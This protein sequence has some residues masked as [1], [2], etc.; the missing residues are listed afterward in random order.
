MGGRASFLWQVLQAVRP[1]NRPYPILYHDV[2]RLNVAKA[3][4][5]MRSDVCAACRIAQ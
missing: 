2:A 4:V 5:L 1:N 3:A